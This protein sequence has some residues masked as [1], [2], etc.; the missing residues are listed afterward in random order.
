[1][2]VV[3]VCNRAVR[4]KNLTCKKEDIWLLLSVLGGPFIFFEKRGRMVALGEVLYILLKKR[5]F[6]AV[7]NV[8][9]IVGS[10][11]ARRIKNLKKFRA[12][13]NIVQ[14]TQN[15]VGSPVLSGCYLHF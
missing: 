10:S 14:N 2:G 12:Y 11:I 1:M 6:I 3:T 15:F 13:A 4:N 7:E 9:F 5:L 8:F